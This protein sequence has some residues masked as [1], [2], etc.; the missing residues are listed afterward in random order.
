MNPIILVTEAISIPELFFYVARNA[1]G[2]LIPASLMLLV[3]ITVI[4]YKA[5]LPYSV[6]LISGFVLF[7]GLFI[8]AEDIY[9]SMFALSL[10]FVF[11]LIGFAMLYFSRR[12]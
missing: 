5:N 3:V 10:M 7:F 12:G 2:G 8:T 9:V 6:A 4:I 11:G 1:M